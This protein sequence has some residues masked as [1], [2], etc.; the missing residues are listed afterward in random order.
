MNYSTLTDSELRKQFGV[1]LR[2]V[3]FVDLTTE[4]A[5]RFIARQGEVEEKV[6]H[7]HEM[8]VAAE[9]PACGKYFDVYVDCLDYQ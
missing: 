9:C 3:D 8:E 5:K 7:V 4:C 2:L 1:T 6:E